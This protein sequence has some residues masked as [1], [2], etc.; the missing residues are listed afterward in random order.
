M[1]VVL[2]TLKA[3]GARIAIDDFGTGYSSLSYL[4]N[5]PIDILKV[6]KAFV[7]PSDEGETNGH[8]I[9]GA[10][11]NLARTLGLRTVAEGVEEPEQAARLIANGCDI[12]QG[13]LWARPLTVEDAERLLIES[14]VSLTIITPT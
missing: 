8:E 9:L 13:F 14:Q 12:G 1:A 7:S 2:S 4:K 5:L 6:D 10:I 3:T 11:L